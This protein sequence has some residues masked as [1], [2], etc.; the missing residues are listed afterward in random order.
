MA[1]T[2]KEK[3][4]LQQLCRD[5]NAGLLSSDDA[6]EDIRQLAVLYGKCGTAQAKNENEKAVKR[7]NKADKRRLIKTIYICFINISALDLTEDERICAAEEIVKD[8]G[9]A[10][11]CK[12][13]G[14]FMDAVELVRIARSLLAEICTDAQNE[15]KRQLLLQRC[16]ELSFFKILFK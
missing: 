11:L 1:D 8:G 5:I 9:F 4:Q 6:C 16:N 7:Q 3:Q 12:K 2:Y 15:E 10:V 13:H 14:S